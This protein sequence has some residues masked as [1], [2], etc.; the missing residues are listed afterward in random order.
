[1]GKTMSTVTPVFLKEMR[2]EVEILKTMDHP[3]I[4]KVYNVFERKQEIHIVMEFC[5]GGDLFSRCP[6]SEV[7]AAN[8]VGQIVS[9]VSY[10]HKH[11]I[12]H[13]DLKLENVLFESRNSTQIKVIDFGLAT[14]Y[15]KD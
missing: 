5:S 8:I 4:V 3:N 15:Y 9:A 13:R 6:Y 2:N 7:D 10:M 14:Y 1:M 12:V 11:G